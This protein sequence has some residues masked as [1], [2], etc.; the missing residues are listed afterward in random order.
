MLAKRLGLRQR[1]PPLRATST[2][3][4]SPGRSFP[5][6]RPPDFDS[7]SPAAGLRREVDYRALARTDRALGADGVSVGG[8]LDRNEQSLSRSARGSDRTRDHGGPVLRGHPFPDQDQ[9]AEPR[10]DMYVATAGLPD[11]GPTCTPAAE[12]AS[13]AGSGPGDGLRAR[14]P[15]RRRRSSCRRSGAPTGR[16][17]PSCASST[18]PVS[19]TASWAASASIATGT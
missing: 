13:R 3:G 17:P 10:A 11:D 16:A 6:V 4:T 14:R 8:G 12:D 15:R 7:G 1:V 2:A 5:R 19:A 18:R 9:P